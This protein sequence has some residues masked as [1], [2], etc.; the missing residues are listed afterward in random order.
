[1]SWCVYMIRCSDAT[2]YT[3]VTTDIERRF[4]EHK[5]G[6]VGSKYTRAR[7]ALHVA[8]MEPC[9]SRSEAQTREAAIKK[10]KKEEKEVLIKKCD[11]T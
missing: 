6:K 2:L 8:Y 9:C 1:M 7:I 5:E 10:L 11:L 4:R 3:G